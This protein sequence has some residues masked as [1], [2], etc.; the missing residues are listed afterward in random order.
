MIKFYKNSSTFT[1]NIITLMSGTTIAQAIPIAISPI[2]TRIYTP[3]DFGLFAF[4]MS[5]ISIVAVIVTGRFELAI[6]LPRK[7]SDALY[8][9]IISSLL[10]L[11][12]SSFLF[13]IIYFF[14]SSITIW[15]GNPNISKWLYFIPFSILLVGLY[16]SLNYWF[17]RKRD[18]K[19]LSMNRIIQSSSTSVTN[20]IFGFVKTFQGGL[21][22]SSILGQ[23]LA[24]IVFTKSIMT[25]EN[26]K[27]IKEIRIAKLIAIARKYKKFPQIDVPSALLNISSHQSIAILF[28]IFFTPVVAGYF[29]L[30]Q[31]ILGLPV[32]IVATAVLDVFKEQAARD[33]RE[34]KNAKEIYKKTFKKLSILAT[35]PTL[36]LY[37]IVVDIFVIVFGQDWRIAGEYA[38]LLLPMLFLQFISS[39]LSFMFYIAE[40]QQYNLYTQLLLFILV[41]TSFYLKLED[42]D[43]IIALSLSFSIF[44]CIQLVL[45]AKIAKVF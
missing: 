18:Y 9:V 42:V 14:N 23:F 41:L 26:R 17:N 20:L 28:N 4:Y 32:S 30:T 19:K 33:Y 11:F 38:Q 5:I 31:R 35:I 22:L 6:M 21:I 3:E 43:T 1:K 15:L 44:Y 13:I 34:Y 7:E 12:I 29:Y 8:I 39:P 10:T 25:V 36:I 45:S 24:L 16:Q 37:F 2:L 27:F 40:K